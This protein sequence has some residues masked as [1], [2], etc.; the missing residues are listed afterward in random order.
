[1]YFALF[2][3][4]AKANKQRRSRTYVKLKSIIGGK[5]YVE[6]IDEKQWLVPNNV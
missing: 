6:R 2:L 1:M 4:K 5:S 3:V